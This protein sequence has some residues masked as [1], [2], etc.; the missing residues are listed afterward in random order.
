MRLGIAQMNSFDK[1]RFVFRPKGLN[2][3]KISQA[4]AFTVSIFNSLSVF[5]IVCFICTLVNMTQTNVQI[6]SITLKTRSQNTL[7]L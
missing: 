2:F 4:N 3:N 5:E 7:L 1:K 6:S